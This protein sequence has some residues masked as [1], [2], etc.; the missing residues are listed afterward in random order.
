M[1]DTARRWE[2]SVAVGGGRILA[3]GPDRD[4]RA[5]VGPATRVVELRG[6]T[7]L[8]GFQDAHVHPIHG[9]IGRLR[10]DLR[11]GRTPA[12]YLEIIATYAAAN[13]DVPWIL[14]GGWSMPDFPGGVPDR[15]ELDRVV[16][17]RPVVLTNRDGHSAW[18]NGR[19]LEIAGV[20]ADTTD[21]AHGRI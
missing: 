8:A 2:E 21:P 18:V 13:P 1:G 14:G 9:G 17:D 15:V 7:L 5:L 19:A 10:C 4:I 12:Q 11:A 20:T 3:V 6:R 16:P